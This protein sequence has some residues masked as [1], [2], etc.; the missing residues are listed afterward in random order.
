MVIA[1]MRSAHVPVK[2]LRLHVKRECIGE[3]R[4]QRAADVPGRRRRKIGRG[5]ERRAAYALEIRGFRGW[6]LHGYA[7]C[8]GGAIMHDRSQRLPLRGYMLATT[9]AREGLHE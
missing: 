6:I 1:K 8:A 2:V 4:I 9:P 7:P 3:Q 5:R